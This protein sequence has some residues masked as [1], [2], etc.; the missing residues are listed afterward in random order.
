MKMNSASQDAMWTAVERADVA[1]YESALSDLHVIPSERH[2]ASPAIPLRLIIRTS[3]TGAKGC[4]KP[5]MKLLFGI[6]LHRSPNLMLL[7]RRRISAVCLG[8]Y[9]HDVKACPRAQRRR[10]MEHSGPAPLNPHARG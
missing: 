2:G 4:E 7:A 8:G 9:L 5:Y 3:K 1:K 10:D 6:P